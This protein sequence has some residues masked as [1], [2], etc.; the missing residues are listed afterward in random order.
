MALV[1][2]DR[3]AAGTEIGVQAGTPSFHDFDLESDLDDTDEILNDQILLNVPVP[4]TS[5]AEMVKLSPQE[6]VQHTPLNKLRMCLQMRRV[7]S[8]MNERSNRSMS[9]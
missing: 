1:T 5:F 8:H 3:T 7:V 2:A 6:Q 4:Q 9:G